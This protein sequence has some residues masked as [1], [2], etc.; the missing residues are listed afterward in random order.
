MSDVRHRESIFSEFVKFAGREWL[1]IG[2][3]YA[4]YFSKNVG[5]E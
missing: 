2:M 1:V 3:T 5:G 4:E